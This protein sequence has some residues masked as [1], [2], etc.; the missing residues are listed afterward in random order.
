VRRIIPFALGGVVVAVVALLAIAWTHAGVTLSDDPVALA[1]VDVQAFGGSVQRVRAV[2]ADGHAVPLT[3]SDG[4]LTPQRK[5]PAG[6]PITVTVTVKRPG[7]DGWLL[8]STKREQITVDA[9]VA[10]V[11]SRWVTARHGDVPV[12]FSAPVAKVAYATGDDDLRR[13]RASAG[14][15][16]MIPEQDA[17]G[18]LRVAAAARSWETLGRATTV[19]WFPASDRDAALVSPAPGGTVGPGDRLTLTFKRPVDDVLGDKDPQISDGADGHWK[20]VDAHTLAFVPTG[21][22]LG[23]DSKVSVTLPKEIDAI[24]DGDTKPTATKSLQWTV[25]AA[26]TLRLHQLLAQAG[27]LPLTW[28]P[29]GDDVADTTAAQARAAVEPPD[30]SFS[31]TYDNTPSE[32]TQ[33]WQPDRVSEITR[34]A[35]M[36]FQD[37]HDLT[38]D[39]IAGPSVWKALIADAIAGKKHEGGYSYVYVHRKVPQKLTLWHNGDVVLTSPGNTGVPAAPTELGTF[40]V[41]EHLR[42]TTMSGTNPDGSTYHDPGVKW[43]SYFNG[44]DALHAFPRASFGTPQSLGCVELPEAAAKKVWP[45][46]PIGTL[47]TIEN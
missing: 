36:M 4:R 44:G 35:V 8:G 19:H 6:A 11:A 23:F 13:H 21:L 24:A 22:G 30:G 26:S 34:G 1:A 20:R 7:W 45:Y 12:R 33:Q 18:T 42:V 25:P 47:V 27:Y 15:S 29:S 39:A 16:V 14:R 9:P 46:T 28:T 2:D 10:E 41:F 38:V 3:V 5:V 37:E 17:A 32:L 40:P 31:W 43:V